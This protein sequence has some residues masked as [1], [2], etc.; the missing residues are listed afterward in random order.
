MKCKYCGIDILNPKSNICEH[1]ACIM[2]K[3]EELF[4]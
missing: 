2:K 3:T 4:E 1:E